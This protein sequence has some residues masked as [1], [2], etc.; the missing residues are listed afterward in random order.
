MPAK[1]IIA[2]VYDFDKTLSPKNMQDYAFIPECGITSEEFWA[3]TI[4]FTKK[5]N[6]DPILSY[7]YQ[8]VNRAK[9]TKLIRKDNLRKL[10]SE[11]K[12]FNGVDTW[13]NRINYFASKQGYHVE[14]YIISSGIKEIIEGTSIANY[15]TKIYASRFVYDD[16][17]KPI[18]PALAINFST[19]TQFLFAI[20]KGV[21]SIT[22]STKLNEYMK[23]EDRRIPFSNIIYIGDGIT[24]VPCMKLTKVNGGHSIAVFEEKKDTAVKLLT[25]GRADFALLADYSKDSQ[26]EIAVQIIINKIIA[27]NTVKIFQNG[28]HKNLTK[29]DTNADLHI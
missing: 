1:K 15:F 26:L 8:M 12:F 24:D 20:N 9:N 28:F 25:E 17:G 13:F 29:G 16:K 10:G 7:M 3:S 22:D 14:H 4:E 18:W 2:I 5:N 19:K 23:D 11:V 21:N 27:K 6:M